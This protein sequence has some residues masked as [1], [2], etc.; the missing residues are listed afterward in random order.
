MRTVARTGSM[1]RMTDE[2]VVRQP[3]GGPL[4]GQYAAGEAWVVAAQG[5]VDLQ[6]M[7]PLADALTEAAG[8]HAVLVLDTSAVTFADSSFLNLLLRIHRLTDLRIAAPAAGVR[9]L[10]DLTGAEHVLNLF[11]TVADATA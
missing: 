1:G 11:G 4:G 8:H 2:G 6:N 3:A 10:L 7:A 9:R 5:E